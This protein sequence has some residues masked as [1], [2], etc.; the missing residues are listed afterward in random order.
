M[1]GTSDSD[2]DRVIDGVVLHFSG[3]LFP[4]VGIKYHE[5]HDAGSM[6]ISAYNDN[7]SQP[8]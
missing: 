7:C 8:T 1:A 5:T 6:C 4:R 3:R 2:S